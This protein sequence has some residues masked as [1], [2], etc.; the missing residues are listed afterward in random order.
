M[1]VA[2]REP[3]LSIPETKCPDLNDPEVRERILA[4]ALPDEK[5]N[6]RIGE[7][8]ELVCGPDDLTLFTSW[9][10][11]FGEARELLIL[12]LFCEGRKGGP[13]HA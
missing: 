1:N 7:D 9:A 10:R 4:N 8:G 13:L 12:G 5:L 6:K 2:E 11:V 3:R